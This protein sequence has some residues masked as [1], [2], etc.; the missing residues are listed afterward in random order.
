MTDAVLAS[1]SFARIGY[2]ERLGDPQAPAVVDREADGLV[3]VGLSRE[4]LRAEPFRQRHL[5]HR[6]LR[7]K[8]GVL[9]RVRG[10]RDALRHR[11]FAGVELEIVEVDVAPAE[12]VVVDD[13]QEHRL[14]LDRAHVDDDLLHVLCVVA[15]RVEEQ[16][17][18]VGQD[19][20]DRLVV[21]AAADEEHRPGWVT[22]NGLLVSV[23]RGPSLAIS[24]V[25]IQKLPR[26]ASACRR[27]GR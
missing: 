7:R 10:E 21:R 6:L 9:H 13:A 26:G 2:G 1:P 5:L 11:R 20:V 8:P 27:G 16:L 17:S 3:H 15:G 19:D 23:P 4:Q 12:T 22:L 25:P 24:Y 18:A 14:P